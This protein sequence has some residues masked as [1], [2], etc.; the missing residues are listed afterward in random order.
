V[1]IAAEFGNVGGRLHG[2]E[3]VFLGVCRS[4]FIGLGIAAVAILTAEPALPMD[5]GGKIRF[6]DE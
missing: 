4:E 1:A 3:T 6:G 5:I 2:P